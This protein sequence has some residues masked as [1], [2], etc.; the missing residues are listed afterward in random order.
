MII[1]LMSNLLTQRAEEARAQQQM[2]MMQQMQQKMD[3][4]TQ[5]FMRRLEDQTKRAT[6]ENKE[7]LEYLRREYADVGRDRSVDD[8]SKID[9]TVINAASTAGD[10]H[11]CSPSLM[12][13]LD[14]KI[15]QGVLMQGPHKIGHGVGKLAQNLAFH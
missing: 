4:D 2:Q 10:T 3:R 6:E 11:S 1:S 13:G 9:L 14:R 15:G 12:Q 5:E 7:M 8:A